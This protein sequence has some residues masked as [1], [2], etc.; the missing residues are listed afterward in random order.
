MQ[1]LNNDLH[2]YMED[3]VGVDNHILHRQK[4]ELVTLPHSCDFCFFFFLKTPVL[5]VIDKLR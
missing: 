1:F 4:Q 5:Y 3:G 2:C